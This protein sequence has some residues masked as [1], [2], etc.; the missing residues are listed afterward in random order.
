MKKLFTFLTLLS[1]SLSFSQGYYIQGYRMIPQDEIQT[2]IENER[3]FH[4]KVAQSMIKD[5]K[6]TGWAMLQRQGGSSNEPNIM[7]Y[8]GVGDKSNLENLGAAYNS[9]Y[10]KV[11]SS[12]DEGIA[13]FVK[14]AI[15][16]DGHGVFNTTLQRTN[17]EMKNNVD[18]FNFI[19]INYANVKGNINEFDKLQ[20][21]IWGNFVK[22]EMNRN[23]GSQ[24]MWSTA[25]KVTPNGNGYNWNYIT[26]DGYETYEDLIAPE[27]SSNTKFPQGLDKI[28]SMMDGGTFY[29]QVVWKILMS[30]NSKGEFK[31]HN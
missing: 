13:T 3:Y 20:K 31:V 26:V 16:I 23:N 29:K 17:R 9:A 15:S 21:D 12:M 30:V 2:H 18:G 19:K 6:A 14:R 25:R 8:V 5:G 11:M 7:F 22:K 28:N 1:V 24:V 27:W 10:K 4:S